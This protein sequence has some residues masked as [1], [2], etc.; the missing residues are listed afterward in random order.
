[1]LW[2]AY[3]SIYAIG[4]SQVQIR[5]FPLRGALRGEREGKNRDE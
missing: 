5:I 1:M 4:I 2:Y 3:V